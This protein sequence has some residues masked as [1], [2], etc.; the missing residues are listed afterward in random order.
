MKT[1]DRV[2]AAKRRAHC[3]ESP[4]HCDSRRDRRLQ[5]GAH[6]RANAEQIFQALPEAHIRQVEADFGKERQ[7]ILDVAAGVGA[8]EL[9]R[10]CPALDVDIR[11]AR[12]QAMRPASPTDWAFGSAP[13]ECGSTCPMRHN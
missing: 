9:Q 12:K 7:H 4:W 10:E 1:L 8:F 3:C 5:E 2:E 13:T 11:A 6:R